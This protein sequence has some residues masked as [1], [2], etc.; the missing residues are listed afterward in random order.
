MQTTCGQHKSETSLEIWLADDMCHLEC[1]PECRPECRRML[2]A[3]GYVI[4]TSSAGTYVICTSSTELLMV[5][6][7]LNYLSTVTGTG[8]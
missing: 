4:H 2:F 6:M 3:G 1:R 7:D 5:S 8:Y